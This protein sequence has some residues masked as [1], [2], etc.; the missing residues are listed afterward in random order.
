MEKD[1]VFVLNVN[2]CTLEGVSIVGF[3]RCFV[4]FCLVRVWNV[5]MI[6]DKFVGLFFVGFVICEKI[7]SLSC[8]IL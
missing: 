2:T 1:F 6:N 5:Y 7:W 4:K 3:G 8:K